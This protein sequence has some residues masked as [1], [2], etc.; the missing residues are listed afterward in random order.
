MTDDQAKTRGVVTM[1]KSKVVKVVIS[2]DGVLVG[3]GVLTEDYEIINCQALLGNSQDESDDTYEE[4]CHELSRLP[5]VEDFWRG[6]VT[7]V[8]P[9]G[10]Y[11]AELID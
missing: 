3:N 8:R 10:N 9:E 4:L 5:Q 1:G 7:V 2:L 6:P 11:C